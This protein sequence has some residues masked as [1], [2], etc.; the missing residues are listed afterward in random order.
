[1]VYVV[2]VAGEYNKRAKA[3]RE[4]GNPGA[5]DGCASGWDPRTGSG[6]FG[7]K[8]FKRPNDIFKEKGRW[9]GKRKAEEGEEGLGR[10]EVEASSKL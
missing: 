7:L 9:M 3:R 2:A 5:G 8:I 4:G 10:E 6:Q 1:M